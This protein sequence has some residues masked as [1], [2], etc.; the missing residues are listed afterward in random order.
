[1]SPNF[2]RLPAERTLL[3]ASFNPLRNACP[4][5]DVSFVTCQLHNHM[6]LCESVHANSAVKT[7]FEVELAK[8]NPLE[9]AIITASP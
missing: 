6:F 5:E 1:M 3:L 8:W 2:N 4:V 9:S 7:F